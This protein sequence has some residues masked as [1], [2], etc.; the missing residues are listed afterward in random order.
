MYV[1]LHQNLCPDAANF[2]IFLGP[3]TDLGSEASSYKHFSYIFA[4]KLSKM[5]P[6]CG[7]I[8]IELHIQKP[9]LVE[10]P[11]CLS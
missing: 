6:I 7:R 1:A 4:Q 10:L 11:E 8:S 5:G 9:S 2:P 3:P